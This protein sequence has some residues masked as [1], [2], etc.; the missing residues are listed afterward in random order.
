MC[1]LTDGKRGLSGL[2]RLADNIVDLETLDLAVVFVAKRTGQGGSRLC[3][4][5][6]KAGRW[7]VECNH[8]E[9]IPDILHYK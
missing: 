2:N 1:F 8:I 4:A 7:D 9:D 3:E 6:G 5:L